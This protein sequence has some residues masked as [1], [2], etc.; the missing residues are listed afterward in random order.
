M[1]K[2]WN[3]ILASVLIVFCMLT[4]MSH[5][6]NKFF[7]KDIGTIVIG[8]IN[9]KQHIQ[10]LFEQI[11]TYVPDLDRD[12]FLN[13]KDEIENNAEA[14]R[15]VGEASKDMLNDI[16]NGSTTNQDMKAVL[17][18]LLYSYD[19]EIEKVLEPLVTKGQV[20]EFIDQGIT[21][22][23]IQE[24]YD[25]TVNS[26]QESIPTS[27][28]KMMKFVNFISQ[29]I[30]FIGSAIGA[31]LIVMVLMLLNR[32]RFKWCFSV[33][34]G[35]VIS[36]VALLIVGQIVPRVYHGMLQQLDYVLSEVSASDFSMITNYGVSYFVIGL[37]LCVGA[38]V[39]A[40]S[41]KNNNIIK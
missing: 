19:N 5:L 40:R 1:K 25:I 22:T 35:G 26:F 36:G 10:T 41:E 31:I 7:I 2:L 27:Y 16:V 38:F 15:I 21:Y 24:V 39:I 8:E 14:N 32:H 37:C 9:L 4:C 30:I 17:K 33:G 3:S 6:A 13:L 23:P 20:H 12:A 18:D 28:M 34:M 29:E 11:E